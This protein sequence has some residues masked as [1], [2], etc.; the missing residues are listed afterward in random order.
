MQ[1][2]QQPKRFFFHNY[3]NPKKLINPQKVQITNC[4]KS[5]VTNKTPH[6]Q[7]SLI[8]VTP[9][10]WVW[11]HAWRLTGVKRGLPKR[12]R[13]ARELEPDYRIAPGPARDAVRDTDWPCAS[14][15]SILSAERRWWVEI[16]R[17]WINL[18]LL[19]SE[20]STFVMLWAKL[21]Q[22]KETS[23]RPRALT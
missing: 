20:F 10:T 18:D 23:N 3:L 12:T 16:E 15:R 2:K 17:F 8:K 5:P 11:K 7:K 22:R 19:S 6:P 4:H 14:H 13:V 9:P 21:H 1:K